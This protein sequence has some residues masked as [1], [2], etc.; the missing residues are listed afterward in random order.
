MNQTRTWVVGHVAAA[1][2]EQPGHLIKGV[3][4]QAVSLGRSQLLPDLH[5]ST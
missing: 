5:I 3:G 1:Q 4:Q 2:V